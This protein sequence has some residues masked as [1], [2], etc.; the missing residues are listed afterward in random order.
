MP[1]V[2]V[3]PACHRRNPVT[4]TVCSN[5]ACGE[6]IHQVEITEDSDTA[7]LTGSSPA[8]KASRRVSQT[9][10]VVARAELRA[11]ASEGKVFEIAPGAEVGRGAD[12]DLTDAPDSE[13]ISRRHARFATQDDRWFIEPLGSTNATKVGD[14]VVL[15][16]TALHSG[17]TV[18]LG[19][20]AFEF[21]VLDSPE[22]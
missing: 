13:F 11:I 18:V 9:G 7:V 12:V 19:R 3:C 1:R 21:R 17:E 10:P 15:G 16:P 2:R 14:D 8:P 5:T 4:A 22:L 20:T 6:P